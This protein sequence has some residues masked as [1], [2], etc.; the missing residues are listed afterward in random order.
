MRGV[1]VTLLSATVAAVVG[2]STSVFAAEVSAKTTAL[3]QEIHKAVDA[4]ATG[5]QAIYKDIHQ[6]A[7]P[8]F[9][10]TRTAGIVAKELKA[11]GFAVK[12]GIGKTGVVGVLRNGDG[13]VFMFRADMDAL[14]VEE[15]TG[16]P[17]ASKDRV[18]NLDGIDLPVSHMRG[19]DAHTI[20]GDRTRQGND[21]A[22]RQMVRRWFW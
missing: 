11:L 12:T 9:M 13:P 5:M 2:I 21:A 18:T 22:E 4:G 16:L 7:E 19:H 1:F 15:K 10:E 8:G 20:W 3:V 6:H 17:Y 14:P